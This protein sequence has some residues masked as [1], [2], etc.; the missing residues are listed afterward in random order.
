MV[1]PLFKRGI[2]SKK[3]EKKN[4]STIGKSLDRRLH[5]K[6]W[7]QLLPPTHK[8]YQNYLLE[9]RTVEYLSVKKPILAARMSSTVSA[10]LRLEN[11]KY[12]CP[13]SNKMF[14]SE[15][16][17]VPYFEDEE[18]LCFWRGKTIF[19]LFKTLRSQAAKREGKKFDRFCQRFSY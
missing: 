18:K 12:F 10:C 7:N 16:I 19:L 9:Q 1:A 6:S 13:F 8:L 2:L 15:S 5:L 11:S 3:E 4:F 17:P 14:I